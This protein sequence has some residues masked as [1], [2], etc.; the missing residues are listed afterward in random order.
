MVFTAETLSYLENWQ[1]VIS[2]IAHHSRYLM[3]S[4]FIPDDPIGF[5]KTP[6][7]LQDVVGESFVIIE[8][9]IMKNSKFIVIFAKSKLIKGE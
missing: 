5:V 6:D 8:T 7:Q 4:L 3:I 9:V 1:E 2:T